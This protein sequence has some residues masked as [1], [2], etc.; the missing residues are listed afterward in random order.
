MDKELIWNK[1]VKIVTEKLL[2]EESEVKMSSSFKDD[3][4]ADSLDVVELVMELE[5]EF[6]LDIP[7]KDAASFKT[8]GDVFDYLYDML[9]NTTTTA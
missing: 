9:N 1:G 4:D 3:L 5:D 6:G 2:V 7:D 8:V